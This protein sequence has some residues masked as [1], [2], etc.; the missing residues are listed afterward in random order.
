MI[1]RSTL[2]LAAL[3]AGNVWAT[4][5]D[6]DVIDYTKLSIGQSLNTDVSGFAL[7]DGFAY[8]A[9]VGKDVGPL[10]VELGVDRLSGEA[11]LFGPTLQ[12]N[13]LDWH[14]NAYLDIDVGD[15]ASVFAG[16]G[17]DY[18]DGEASFFG[19]S[20]GA[21]GDGWNWAVGGAYRIAEGLTAEAQFR[22][23]D[24]D[25]STDFGDVALQTDQI[26]LGLRMAL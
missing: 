10:R 13:A 22:R 6:A 18:I 15:R 9:G 1:V 4:T 17:L 2:A 12:A 7:D 3:C 16:A 21:S 14:A 5:A 23:V 20:I 19:N 26:T 24:A 25:L 11:N 8:G